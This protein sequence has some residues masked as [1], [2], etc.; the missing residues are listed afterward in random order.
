MEK[1]FS[2]KTAKNAKIALHIIYGL[3]ALAWDAALLRLKQPLL[4][5]LIQLLAGGALESGK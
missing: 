5:Q 3:S 2:R 1:I 4:E